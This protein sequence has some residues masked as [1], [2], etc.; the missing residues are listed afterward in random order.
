VRL[1]VTSHAL[2]APSVHHQTCSRVKTGF[3]FGG[4]ALRLRFEAG[5]HDLRESYLARL[6]PALFLR[7]A[8]KNRIKIGAI[9]FEET[10]LSREKFGMAL[11]ATCR[12]EELERFC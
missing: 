4:R 1:L 6:A 9:L 7:N 3:G 5:A 10:R 8:R 12:R 2:A 11:G